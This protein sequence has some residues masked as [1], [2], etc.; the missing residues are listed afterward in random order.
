MASEFRFKHF[1]VIND[2][3]AQKVGTDGVLL[4]SLA[5]I[6]GNETRI[7]D[8]GTGT[9]LVALMLAQRTGVNCHIDALEIDETSAAEAKVNFS[10]S[11]WEDRLN[12][13]PLSLQDFSANESYPGNP[14][15]YSL[16][17]S[18]PPYYDNSLK[19]PDA[20]RA[21]AR[22]TD[23]LSYREVISFAHDFLDGEG[24][25]VLV[26]PKQDEK[27]LSRFAASFGFFPVRV[28]NV[29]TTASKMPLRMVVELSRRKAT[30]RTEELILMENGSYTEQYRN[31]TSDFYL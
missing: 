14:L 23:S 8:I 19:A 28:V 15:K 30:V 31:L 1:S 4:G 10:R 3:S 12:V 7:L 17:V 26:L 22:S 21:A 16:I 11:A 29:R 9:G 5:T 6:A 24:R 13:I 27:Q 2:K 25:V 20:R 18:N